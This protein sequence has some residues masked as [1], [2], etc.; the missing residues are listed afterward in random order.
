MTDDLCILG[1]IQEDKNPK[2]RSSPQN[3]QV[4]N[5]G[6]N[7]Q[8]FRAMCHLHITMHLIQCFSLVDHEPFGGKERIAIIYGNGNVHTHVGITIKYDLVA[9]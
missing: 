6:L 7:V 2:V 1:R 3:Y 9:F 5:P 8:M 4:I